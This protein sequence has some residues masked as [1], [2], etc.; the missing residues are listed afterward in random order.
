MKYG[1]L[2]HVSWPQYQAAM[3]D[4]SVPGD[5]DVLEDLG[6]IRSPETL[7]RHVA[8]G[9]EVARVL[10]IDTR[11]PAEKARDDAHAYY[12]EEFSQSGVPDLDDQ[13][14]ETLARG[15]ALARAALEHRHDTSS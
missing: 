11:T 13:Q 10:G 8:C 2:E 4:L 12:A 5:D 3:R 1:G 15:L 9:A 14:R 6:Y 7:A